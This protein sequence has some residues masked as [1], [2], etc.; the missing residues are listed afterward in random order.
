MASEDPTLG[1]IE[2]NIMRE[3]R[4][5]LDAGTDDSRR[6]HESNVNRLLDRWII[7]MNSKM[8]ADS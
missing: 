3:R 4:E 7:V 6:F 1:Y 2:K 8:G 5:W